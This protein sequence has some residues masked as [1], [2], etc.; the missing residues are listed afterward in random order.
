MLGCFS[1][2][3]LFVIPR[4]ISCQASLSMGFSRQECWNEL[5]CSSPGD[6]PDLGL[7]PHLLC[8]LHWQAG[9]LPLAP[10]GTEKY[11][12]IQNNLPAMQKIQVRS[13][14]WEDPL[15]K[16]TATH[17]SVLAWR[18]PGTEEPGGLQSMGV[19]K[20]QTRLSKKHTQF[21]SVQSLSHVRLF[22]TP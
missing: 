14:G 21:S 9:S 22:A 1:H 7:N 6:L 15:E 5:P 17:S 19:I 4:T 3:R 10:P 12:Y 2:A 11:T 13:L 20:S 8:L 16:R 18:I